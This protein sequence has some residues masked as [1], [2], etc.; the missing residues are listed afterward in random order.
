M[1]S[2]ALNW[3]KNDVNETTAQIKTTLSGFSLPSNTATTK[4]TL[5]KQYYTVSSIPSSINWSVS[6]NIINISRLNKGENYDITISYT[7][8]YTIDYY[9]WESSEDGFY[10]WGGHCINNGII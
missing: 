9:R 2:I 3:D 4:Y 5:D 1:A 6:G 10:K 7:I 8:E